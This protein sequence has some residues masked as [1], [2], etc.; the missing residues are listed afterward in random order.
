MFKIKGKLP[1]GSGAIVTVIFSLLVTLQLTGCKDSGSVGGSFPGAGAEVQ[2]DTLELVE[3]QADTLSAIS[4]GLSNFSIGRFQ[5]PVFGDMTAT[6]LVKP[7]LPIVDTSYTIASDTRMQLRLAVNKD[8]IYGDT[9]AAGEFDVVELAN[10]F[11]GNQVNIDDEVQTTASTVGSFTVTNED[12]ISVELS[13]SWIQKYAEFFNDTSATKDSVYTRQFPGLAIVPQNSAKILPI[14]PGGSSFLATGLEIAEDADSTVSD[15]LSIGLSQWAFTLDRTNVTETDPGTSIIHNTLERVQWFKF[16]FS[17]ENLGAQNIAQVKLV[18]YRDNTVLNMS[19]LGPNEVR[20]TDGNLRLHLVE[21]DELPQSIDPGT[22][23]RLPP[24][25]PP[26]TGFYQE[27][28]GAY[29]IDITNAVLSRELEE[30]APEDRYYMTF[31]QNDGTIRST[32]FFNTR[33]GTSNSPKVIVTSTKT[34]DN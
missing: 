27:D 21:G 26:E 19:P 5:D 33:A 29:Y 17:R 13:S 31:G 25:F 2:I 6:G 9:L 16:D 30:L 20:R 11:R 22:P 1:Q 15:S 34:E 4:G 3:L 18:F 10:V 28:D 8:A 14:N 23:F 32:I 12:T 7:N 24:P